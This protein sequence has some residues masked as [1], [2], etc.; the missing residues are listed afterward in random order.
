[1]FDTHR[2]VLSWRR[3]YKITIVIRTNSTQQRWILVNNWGFQRQQYVM[4]IAT[5]IQSPG[6]TDPRVRILYSIEVHTFCYKHCWWA[7]NGTLSV[8]KWK[9]CFLV[10]LPEWIC[11]FITARITRIMLFSGIVSSD[12]HIIKYYWQVWHLHRSQ[13]MLSSENHTY[14]EKNNSKFWGNFRIKA[15]VYIRY[16]TW[17]KTSLDTFLISFLKKPFLQ[18]SN[19]FWLQQ[20]ALEVTKLVKRIDV[21]LLDFIQKWMWLLSGRLIPDMSWL[22]LL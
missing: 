21:L 4:T 19:V 5:N 22:A 17:W 11:R 6:H 20:S 10:F 16:F 18:M 8:D 7:S 14:H 12:L 2:Y 13:K 1:M 15:I 3:N 9:F